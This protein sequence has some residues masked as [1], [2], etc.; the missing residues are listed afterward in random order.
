M[1]PFFSVDGVDNTLVDLL[2]CNRRIRGQ[3]EGA[4]N[5]VSADLIQEH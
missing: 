3:S 1:C 5:L 4:I 2:S